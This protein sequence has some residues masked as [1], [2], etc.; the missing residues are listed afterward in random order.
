MQVVRQ[1]QKARDR[2][3]VVHL[4]E[5]FPLGEVEVIIL[6]AAGSATFVADRDVTHELSTAIAHFLTLDTS[7]FS[8]TER[9]A[10]EQA[11]ETLKRGRRSGE[12]RILGLFVQLAQ[13]ADDFDDPLPDEAL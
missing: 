4:P 5:D 1:I 10:Y 12:P 2:K 6:P 8:A 3:V 11:R 7:H 9:Q 13:M